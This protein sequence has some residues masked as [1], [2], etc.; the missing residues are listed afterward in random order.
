ML[1]YDSVVKSEW[2]ALD[3]STKGLAKLLKF[4]WREV[5]VALDHAASIDFKEM[6]R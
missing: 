5:V 1:Y 6:A 4:R 2:L 3:G